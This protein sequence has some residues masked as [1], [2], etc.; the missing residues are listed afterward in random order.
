MILLRLC[1]FSVT[2]AMVLEDLCYDTLTK[3]GQ[4]NYRNKRTRNVEMYRGD[5]QTRV[6]LHCKYTY[7][8]P[9]AR[10][11]IYALRGKLMV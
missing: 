6:G 5:M 2:I 1:F 7:G 10:R 3:M 11:G 4:R 9:A 8:T